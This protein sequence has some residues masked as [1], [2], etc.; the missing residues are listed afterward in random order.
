MVNSVRRP[1]L[2]FPQLSYQIIGI[3]FSVY[4][5]L[6]PGHHERYYQRSVA[7]ALREIKLP[8]KEQVSFP[9]KFRTALIGRYQLDFLVDEK[10]VLELKKGD[11]FSK[12]HIDQVLQYL[13]STNLKLAILA[14]FAKSGVKFKRIINF[15][16]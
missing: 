9:L 10:I 13:K 11:N 5:E 4:N 1:D 3:L 15:E 7:Q 16:G 8:F 2:I 6:G 12:R 14:N